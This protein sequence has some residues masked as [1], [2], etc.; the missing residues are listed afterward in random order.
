M[1]KDTLMRAYPEDKKFVNDEIVGK[2]ERDRLHE[3]V[4]EYREMRAK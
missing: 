2:T 1:A 4:R 3:I